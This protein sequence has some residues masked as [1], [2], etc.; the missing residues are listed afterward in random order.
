MGNEAGGKCTVRHP[1]TGDQVT[2][3]IG[4]LV[5]EMCAWSELGGSGVGGVG[6]GL[7]MMGTCLF[8][9]S[10][11]TIRPENNRLLQLETHVL[12]NAVGLF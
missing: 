10:S 9:N 12:Q 7:A 6:A 8:L 3:A 1:Q 5:R 11:R 4:L 2:A